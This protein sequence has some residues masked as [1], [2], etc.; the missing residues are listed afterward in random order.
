MT[1]TE[2]V[3][4][5]AA[6][7]N[8][9]S[10]EATTRIG[11]LVN[12]RYRRLV[13]SL[14][15]DTS[16]RTASTVN[17]SVSSNEIT[18][19]SYNKV[20]RVADVSD[21]NVTVLKEVS[22]DELRETTLTASDSPT[23]WAVKTVG[24]DSVVIAFDVTF[25]TTDPDIRVDGYATVSTI[26][27]STEPVFPE[28]FHDILI[29]GVVADELMKMEKKSL[30]EKW[31][32]DY[33]RRMSE[34]R[35]YLLK[36]RYI[37]RRQG[38]LDD[39]TSSSAGAGASSTEG[40]TSYTQ[41]GLITFD[42]DP[43]APFAVVSGSAVVANLDADKLDGIDSTGFVLAITSVDNEIVR[44]NGTGGQVQGSGITIADGAAGTLAGSNSGDVTL[45]GSPDYI[46]I[47]S[48]VIT[49]ALINLA[50]H[51]TGR[52]PFANFVAATDTSKIVGRKTASGGSFEECSLSD[53]LD[54]IGSAAQGDI[55]YRGAATWA[56][57]GAGTSGHFLK[58]QGAAANPTWAA[59]SASSKPNLTF[60]PQAN[61]PPTATYATPDTRNAVPVLDF[62]AD[63]DEYAI[64]GGV[65]GASYAGGGL[66]VEIYWTATSATTGDAVW[67]AEIER[68]NTDLDADSFA[69]AQTTTSTTNG[70][71]GIITKTTIT[72][73]DGAQMDSLAAGEAFRIRIA[74]DANA[75]GDTMTGD[76]ELHRV[77]VRET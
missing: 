44:F 37:D 15:L 52:L 61:Q 8:L 65:L 3:T 51:V 11:R 43:S 27:G 63:A 20:T 10:S 31:E 49:R 76:A 25:Q 70:T 64:F 60:T 26:S 41:T 14:N 74:R 77:V 46:T 30:S 39:P 66:T 17:P 24:A 47:A 33:N 69:A 50:S 73:T 59:V 68:M 1:F 16:T 42:R 29:M 40:T 53:V 4:E 12:I 21:G 5:I 58:T 2:I 45:G 22:W 32:R 35:M 71:S 48:Q 55:L 72:F 56:R 38:A 34:L 28:T 19:S 13:S 36:S 75:A 18:L 54:M 9:T 23:M 6:H 67:T 57:L 7:L 62:D